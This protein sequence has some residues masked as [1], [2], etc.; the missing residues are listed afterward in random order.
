M[1]LNVINN[2]HGADS[3]AWY[4][5]KPLQQYHDTQGIDTMH[6]PEAFTPRVYATHLCEVI[7]PCVYATRLPIG[8]TYK[9]RID[10][11]RLLKALTPRIYERR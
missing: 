6:L 11:M 4:S 2:N 5:L 8:K 9:P 7:T 3:K 10:A 1:K